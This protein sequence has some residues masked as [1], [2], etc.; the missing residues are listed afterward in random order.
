MWWMCRADW[1]E[2]ADAGCGKGAEQRGYVPVAGWWLGVV[3]RLGQRTPM[4]GLPVLKQK[5]NGISPFPIK[6]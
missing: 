5:K 4:Q 6:K 3:R 1:D 2:P